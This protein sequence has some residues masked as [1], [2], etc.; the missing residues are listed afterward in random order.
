MRTIYRGAAVHD[1]TGAPPVT[2]DLVVADGRIEAAGHAD[3]ATPV[4]DVSGRSIIPGL[5]DCHTHVTLPTLDPLRLMNTPLSHRFLET[6]RTL[7]TTLD[8]GITTVRDAGGADAGIAQAVAD[9]VVRGPRVRTAI[10]MISPTGGHSDPWRLSG[11]DA[12]WLFPLYPGMPDSVADGPVGL[13]RVVREIVRAGAD[14]I[15]VAVSG[16]ISSPR[17]D[18]RHCQLRQDELGALVEEAGAA[19][20]RVMAHAH[21]P[22]AITAAVRAGVAS[23]EHGVF[24][25]EESIALMVEHGTFLVPTLTAARAFLKVASADPDSLAQAREAVAVHETNLRRALAAGVR[26]AMGSDSGFS[27]HGRNLDELAA[28]ASAGLDRAQVLRSATSGAAE[29]LGLDHEI[30]TLRPGMRADFCVVT[31]DP[32]DFAGLAD[33]IEAVY[34]DG[35]LVGGTAFT[36]KVEEER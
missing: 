22:A 21:G 19:G 17:D 34:Q 18:P 15:K 33:R 16:G 9:G 36:K 10:A 26:V 31:G 12:R 32:L 35:V 3:P 23:I 24:I 30:G 14:V 25:D 6:G 20:L 2:A 11:V 7:A 27:P 29:L 4:V 1:G 5:I 13:R 8:L 28:L